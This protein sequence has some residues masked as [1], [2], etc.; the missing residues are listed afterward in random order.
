MCLQTK[1]SILVGERIYLL[2]IKALS[3]CVCMSV[4]VCVCG[5]QVIQSTLETLISYLQYDNYCFHER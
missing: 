2:F 3:V 1:F 4:C 5:F